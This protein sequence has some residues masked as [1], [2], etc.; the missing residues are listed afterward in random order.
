MTQ[1]PVS[2][3]FMPE[4]WDRH[5]HARMPRAA[6]A[7][8]PALE[9]LY[10]GRQRFLF[11]TFGVWG[12]GQERPALGRGQIATVIRYGFDL[13]PVLLGTPLDLADAWGFYPRFRTLDEVRGLQ[14][15]DI[16]RHP[17]GEWLSREAAT[18]KTRYGGC[19][20]CIDIGSVTNNAFRILGESLYVELI[21]E[22]VAVS[23]L[24]EAVL[25]TMEHLYAF[26]EGLFGGM[27]PVPISNCNVSLMGPRRYEDLVLPF[28]ARQNRFAERRRGSPPRAAVHHCDVPVDAFLAAYAKLPG[29]ASLQAAITSDIAAARQRLPQSEFSALVSPG[30]LAG[31]PDQ[32]ESHLRR[33]ISAGAAN[34]AFWNIDAATSITSVQSA[35]T[36]IRSIGAGHGRTASFAA[37]PL[38]WE[39]IEWAHGR[40]REVQ[41]K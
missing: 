4:W 38:C 30:L 10:L 41:G 3:Y 2:L 9:A 13:V 6:T 18:L 20:H 29:V 24:F 15:V 12:C 21:A 7:S 36:M 14:P 39:E 35:L 33:A 16:A 8:R 26:L 11:E 32:L 40:H 31:T 25:Q 34:L 17:E 5:F 27:G 28:D 19:S 1:L 37:M 23:A 22:P